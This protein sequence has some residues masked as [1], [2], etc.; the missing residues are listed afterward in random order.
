MSA[1]RQCR[2]ACVVLALAAAGFAVW[3]PI[4]ADTAPRAEVIMRP[5]DL[6]EQVSEG[7]AAL[8]RDLLAVKAR[9][10]EIGDG[11][12]QAEP[13]F[14]VIIVAMQRHAELGNPQGD[15]VANV[16]SYIKET[17]TLILLAEEEEDAQA[18]VLLTAELAAFEDARKKVIALYGDSFREVRDVE[19][20]KRRFVLNI[21]TRLSKKARGAVDESVARMEAFKNRLS[22]VRVALPG[23][24]AG[25][26]TE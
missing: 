5:L 21:R 16:E 3:A 20:Q 12:D 1:L 23:G 6:L 19:S 7:E 11:L 13:V 10:T 9:L 8:N 22:A 14:S 18:R 24:A 26:L 2:R 25:I 17:K 4:M 15:F